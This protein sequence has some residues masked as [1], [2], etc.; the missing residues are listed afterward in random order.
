VR[1]ADLHRTTSF[2][3]ALLF[4]L[5]FGA[6]TIALFGF[7]YW[8]TNNYFARRVEDW[9][10]GEQ[11]SFIPMDRASVLARLAAHVIAD[12]GLE[13]PFTLFDSAGHVLAGSPLNLP[14]TVWASLPRDRLFSFSM[15]QGDGFSMEQGDGFTIGQGDGRV[16]FLG[17]AHPMASGE[18]LL[19][20]QDMTPEHEFDEVLVR[21]FVW[22]CLATA[23]LGLAGAAI[24]GADA[25]RRIDAVTRAIQRIISGDFS[26]RLPARGR[27][28][29][30][31]RL[32]HVVNDMLAEIE[33]LMQEVKG[34]CDNIAHDLRTPMTRLLAGLERTRRRANSADDYAAAVDEAILETKSVLATFA[35]ML[36]VSE[37]ENGARRAGF[38]EVDLSEVV[39]DAVELYEPM[40]E[41]KGVSLRLASEVRTVAMR[42]DRSLLFEVTG[43]LVDNALKFTP[44]GGLITARSFAN[45]GMI[46]I[47]VTDT[48][49]GIPQD[50]REAVLRRF[51]RTEASRHTPGSGLGL[52]LVAAVAR[53]H[54]MTLTIT[55]AM[56][57]CRITVGCENPLDSAG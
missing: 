48:G 46:G 4:L 1:L 8:Q 5:L 47:E 7:L 6:S 40:A 9:L 14:A 28:G 51:Y 13:R 32:V 31:D 37:V 22:G 52:A 29:D 19:I 10:T 38:E 15:E 25:A 20:A 27:T 24:S 26:R 55:D 18:L 39:A 35:A 16:T 33:R 3:L 50:E 23:I 17:L 2:R 44:P 12:R 54:G 56:P 53:L 43:N 34:I 45:A 36:R 30:F 41:E 42:G 11:A 49:P 21:S 57:G